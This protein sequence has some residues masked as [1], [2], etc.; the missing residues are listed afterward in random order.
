MRNIDLTELPDI[1]YPAHP[2]ERLAES[3]IH[4]DYITLLVD[5]LRLL[6]RDREHEVGIFADLAW[7]PVAGDSRIWM[8]PDVMVCFGVP[9]YRPEGRE[10]YVQHRE[11]G[12]IPSIVF[13]IHSN[14]N[15]KKEIA[16]KRDWY[17]KYG[18]QEFYWLFTDPAEVR[19]FLR[20]EN[21]LK[22]QIVGTN[23]TSEILG[24]RFDW[25]G[26]RLEIY[27]PNGELLRPTREYLA[28][29]AERL[30]QQQKQ[31]QREKNR[32]NREAKAKLEAEKRAETEAKAK[33]EAESRAKQEEEKAKELAQQN[34]RL[35]EMLKQLGIDPNKIPPNLDQ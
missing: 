34:E 13:E 22:E 11:N 8:A 10:S 18:V 29:Q 4:F 15:T 17:E 14:S 27:G 31:L 32:A 33:L 24:I 30:A 9:Q 6:F 1:E 2:E 28:I 19:V 26:D 3:Q 21:E 12:V 7:Y 25:S 5:N 35:R 23:W 16:E 20:E